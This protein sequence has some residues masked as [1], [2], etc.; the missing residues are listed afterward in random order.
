MQFSLII[1]GQG[2]ARASLKGPI[3]PCSERQIYLNTVVIAA[4]VIDA[5]H[6]LPLPPP[7]N[8]RRPRQPT[9]S[10]PLELRVIL[11]LGACGKPLIRQTKWVG[12]NC[13]CPLH[14]LLQ[15]G[16]REPAPGSPC[17]VTAVESVGKQGRGGRSNLVLVASQPDDRCEL[18]RLPHTPA[19]LQPQRVQACSL[20][21]LR[22]FDSSCS[23]RFLAL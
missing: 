11:K 2:R 23:T 12:G 6:G 13:D 19:G 8:L 3:G 20:L 1:N 9:I 22:L 17:L 10:T 18:R 14:V 7:S 21:R 4:V 16:S 15:L 5:S